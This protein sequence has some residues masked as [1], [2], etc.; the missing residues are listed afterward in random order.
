MKNW[1][2]TVCG[3]ALAVVAAVQNYNGAN[4]WQGWLGVILI[5]ALGA[6]AKDFN[7]AA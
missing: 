1:R 4:T 7:S 5:A 3:L 6:L 2:T